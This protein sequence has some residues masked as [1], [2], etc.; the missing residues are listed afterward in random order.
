MSHGSEKR[1]RT[2]HLTIRFTPEERAIIDHKADR[3]GLT[4]GSYARQVILGAP[5]PRQVRRPPVERRELARLLGELGRV[6][7]NLNQL[8]RIANAGDGI[9]V[10]DFAEALGGLGPV[11]DAILTALGRSP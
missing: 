9:D 3:A 11:R 7:N 8:A 2:R 6:G 4:S 5:A 1:A 10:V